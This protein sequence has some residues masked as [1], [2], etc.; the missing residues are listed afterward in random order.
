MKF[1]NEIIFFNALIRNTIS[2]I[3]PDFEMR[4]EENSHLK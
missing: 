4:Q 1:F 3:D 2:F